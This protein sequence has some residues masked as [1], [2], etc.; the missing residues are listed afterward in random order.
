MVIARSH[1]IPSN[2]VLTERTGII[3]LT[4]NQRDEYALASALSSQIKCCTS[5]LN[6]PIYEK[7]PRV[8]ND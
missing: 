4:C 5:L 7:K 8:G 2:D 1:L 6:G 3:V